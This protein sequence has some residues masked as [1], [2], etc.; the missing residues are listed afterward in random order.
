MS[1]VAGPP[2][3]VNGRSQ[4][5]GE[6]TPLGPFARA[7]GRSRLIVMLAVIAVMVIAVALFLLGTGL[8]IVGV[9]HAAQGVLRGELGSTDLT[10]EF[11][12]VVSVMLK[13][14]VFYLI[15]V[16]LYS[17]FIAPLN[18]TAALGVETLSDLESKVISVVIVIMSVTFLEHFIRWKEPMETLQFGGALSLVVSALV[19]FQYNSHHAKEEQRMHDPDTQVRAQRELFQK[20]HEQ[21]EVLPDEERGTAPEAEHR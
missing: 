13:A 9:W 2:P 7:I 5:D 8:A 12:E 17:L 6:T 11:L 3:S 1:R 19:L 20:D 10:V 16:G 21:R 4:S 18:L 15:G 14:V